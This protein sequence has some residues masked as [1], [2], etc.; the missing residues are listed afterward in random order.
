MLAELRAI[1]VKVLGLRHVVWLELAAVHQQQF[2]AGGRELF[3]RGAADEP[4]AAQDDDF[5]TT[6]FRSCS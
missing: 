5:Q 4:R 2:V 3:D 6:A 1:A